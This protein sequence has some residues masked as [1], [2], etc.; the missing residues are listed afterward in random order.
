MSMHA[1]EFLR[2]TAHA[3][4]A[5]RSPERDRLG[6]FC[7]FASSM[8]LY[9]ATEAIAAPSAK[10]P[11]DNADIARSLILDTPGIVCCIE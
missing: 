8:C 5:R 2:T 4:L 3:Q 7:G 6:A 11:M 10:T 1:D 9:F